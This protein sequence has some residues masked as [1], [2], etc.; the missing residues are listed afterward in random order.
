M[1][2]LARYTA[3][4]VL[5]VLAGVSMASGPVAKVS[6]AEGDI[7]YSRDGENWRP[8]TRNKYLFPGYLVRSGNS[9][10]AKVL[11]Q[12]SGV[13]HDLGVRTTIRVLPNDLEV[14]AGSNF[15]EPAKAGGS[16]WQAMMNKFS[17]TQRYTTVRR[18]VKNENDPPRVDTARDLAVSSAWPQLVWTNAGPEYAYRLTVADQT[19]DVRPVSTGEMI[20]FSLPDLEPGRHE[21]QVE[22]LLDG[23]VVYAPRRP[24]ELVWLS[25]RQE[26]D[27]MRGLDDLRNDPM[28]NDA[29]VLA[30][31]LESHDLRVGAMDLYRTFFQDYPDENDMRPYLIKAYHDLK[32]LDLKEKEAITYNTIE[33]Q[34]A[35][36]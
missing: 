14:V 1:S 22:V 12:E 24:S 17:T 5:T 4:L 19:F 13:T 9:G 8:I 26:A 25:E 15:S 11:N 20:R 18:S 31:Y 16:F 6:Q 27:V 23:E 3:T 21:Y 33:M 30:D 34:Q 29:F 28:Q 32:L 10:S 35:A 36:M 2:K 7:A